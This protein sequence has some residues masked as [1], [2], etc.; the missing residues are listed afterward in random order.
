MREVFDIGSKRRAVF[1]AISRTLAGGS[2][3]QVIMN[4]ILN[5]MDAMLAMPSGQA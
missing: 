1:E 4:L 5:S 3:T 2:T